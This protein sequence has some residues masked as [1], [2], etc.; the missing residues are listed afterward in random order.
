MAAG[1]RIRADE[2][3]AEDTHMTMADRIALVF[4]ALLLT[5]PLF[6]I[7]ARGGSRRRG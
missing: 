3:S 1:D 6:A 7:T 4:V 2:T 5:M